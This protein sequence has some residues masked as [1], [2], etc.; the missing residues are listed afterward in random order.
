MKTSAEWLRELIAQRHLKTAYAAAKLIGITPTRL[1]E[2]R[3]GVRPFNNFTAVRVAELLEVDPVVVI[4]SAEAER[5]K[6]GAHRAYWEKLATAA[7]ILLGLG[8]AG[9]PSPSEASPQKTAGVYYVKS[10][11]RKKPRARAQSGALAALSAFARRSASR[12]PLLAL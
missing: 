7:I 4:A 1:Y 5:E 9:Q 3:D 12:L 2:Y 10:G 6:G 8:L 11:R